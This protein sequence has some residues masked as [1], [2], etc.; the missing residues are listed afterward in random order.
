MRGLENLGSKMQVKE[1]D[2]VRAF[3]DG[4]GLL[5]EVYRVA[6]K[7]MYYSPATSPANNDRGESGWRV[8]GAGIE[9]E[10]NH[11]QPKENEGEEDKNMV[12]WGGIYVSNNPEIRKTVDYPGQNFPIEVQNAIE[13]AITNAGSK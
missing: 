4:K 12:G 6:E 13:E 8:G 3:R 7:A 5:I 11:F 2:R 10:K 9:D 1:G